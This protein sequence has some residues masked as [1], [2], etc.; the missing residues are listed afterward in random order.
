VKGRTTEAVTKLGW[1]QALAWRMGRHHL[2]ERAPAREM[3][4]VTGRICGLHA[5][6]MSS[7]ELTLWARVDGLDR[8]A[9]QKAL[10]EE[11]SLVKLWAMRG[12]L[13]LLPAAEIGMWLAALGTYQH[14]KKAAWLRG[15]GIT[16]K[17]LE[18]LIGTVEKALDGEPL[19]RD[20]L[21]AKV[22]KLTRSKAMGERIGGSWGAYLK[23][24]SFQGRLCFGPSEGQRVRFTTPA[25]WV[26]GGVPEVDPDDA[27]REIT[28]R[29]LAAYAPAT[30]E[31][32][33]RWW[34][35][36]PVQAGRMLTALGDEAVEV[37]V[38]GESCWMLAEHAAEAA[39]LRKPR[40]VARLLPGFDQW[41]VGASRSAP[42]QLNPEHK[43]RVHRPQGWISPVLLVNGRIDGVWKYELRGGRLLIEIEPFGK[44]PVWARKQATAE[45]GRLAE[46]LGGDLE[47]SWGSA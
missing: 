17:E 18:R 1:R 10:W 47:L 24:A 37:D 38:D 40:N 39:A 41:A 27:L 29:Y 32:L 14:Y 4:E 16:E 3:V 25:S 11:R 20:E 5:Q 12:T 33:R 13:H 23:P 19:T 26:P 36:R 45:A 46:Y 35:V 21:G 8:D 34:G 44:L 31:D 2:V 9:M 6:V 7:A 43:A 30:R 22:A 15:F 28:R 42:A